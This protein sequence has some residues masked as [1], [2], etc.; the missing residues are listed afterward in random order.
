[1]KLILVLNV[2]GVINSSAAPRRAMEELMVYRKFTASIVS[3]DVNTMGML[4][5]CK[6]YLSWSPVDKELLTEL[7]EK[8]GMVSETKK[9]DK[10]ALK[11]LGFKDH[12]EMA[13]KMIKDGKRLSSFE[14]VRPFFK[15]APPKGGFKKTM[16]RQ[17]AE[18][19]MLGRNLG[20]VEIVRRML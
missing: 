1:M 5:R 6:D 12:G 8:K 19:G 13:E 7:L 10:A 4:K 14:G 9:L 11:A 2:H 15:L 18:G 3:D 16:R 20:L 17:A